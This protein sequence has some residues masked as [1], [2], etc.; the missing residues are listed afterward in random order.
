MATYDRAM[1]GNL[2]VYNGSE[3]IPYRSLQ[4]EH[5]FFLTDEWTNGT[6]LYD[7][8]WFT[9]LPM[10]FDVEKELV[11][12]SYYYKGIK[13]QLNSDRVSE[14]TLNGHRFIN[15]KQTNDSIAVRKGFYNVL[16][17]GKTKVFV[18]RIKKYFEKINETQ[19]TQEFKE[20]SQYYLFKH[21]KYSK[22]GTKRSILN[23]LSERK[24]ELKIYI[25]KNRL[26]VTDREE[27]LVRVSQFYDS[28][29]P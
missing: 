14:F 4:D 11:V 28:L 3:Y 18:K 24:K 2:H 19:L 29:K 5:P 21:G 22:V 20:S 26:F 9:E 15:L 23:L 1:E 13:M 10:L 6:I 12:I 27:S 16:Y 8:E 17:D 7:G 25:R